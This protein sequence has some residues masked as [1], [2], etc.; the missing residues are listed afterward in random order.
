MV[1]RQ[2]KDVYQ[3]ITNQVLEALDY[4][5]A[6][7][8]KLNW[9]KSW[10][11][12]KA[13]SRPLRSVP[14]GTPY[15]GINALLLLMSSSINGFDSPYFMTYKQAQEITGLERPVIKG[16]KGT[17]DVFYKQITREEKTTD[18]NGVET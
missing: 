3:V 4:A 11:S 14:F 7:N 17:M 16:S 6:N 12:G 18:S 1:K 2:K 5:K 15:K 13:I 9:T 10:K 8:I